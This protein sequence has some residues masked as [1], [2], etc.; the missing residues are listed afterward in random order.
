MCLDASIL[1]PV[2]NGSKYLEN[3]FRSLIKSKELSIYNV[4]IIF[5]DDSS[6]DKTFEM[7]NTLIKY[8]NKNNVVLLR[9]K[10]NQGI[11]YSL[12]KGIDFSKGKY[13]FRL[14]I[15]DLWTDGR[16]KKSINCFNKLNK[17]N[18]SYVLVGTFMKGKSGKKYSSP[19]YVKEIKQLISSSC[20]YHP[21]WCI[22]S[23]ILRKYKYEVPSP[24]EDYFLV[25]RILLDNYFIYNIPEYLVLYNDIS[26]KDRITTKTCNDRNV[27][28][29]MIKF[30]I[31]KYLIISFFKINTNIHKSHLLKG[32]KDVVLSKNKYKSNILISKL[33]WIINTIVNKIF[34]LF[35]VKSS[36]K[37]RII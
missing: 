14:D 6:N 5:I 13:I 12:N 36:R 31:L 34:F 37:R 20:V 16:L 17:I 32:F 22:K 21:S 15:D 25:L 35:E 9:N 18:K 19:L 7:L 2:Y 23:E 30:L 1:I 26:S 3:C 4:E 28:F 33:A 27:N 10:T 11:S 8:H 24:W 29:V